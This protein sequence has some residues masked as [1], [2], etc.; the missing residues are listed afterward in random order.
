MSNPIKDF[1]L[2][3][4]ALTP[5]PEAM[6]PPGSD[7]GFQYI[8]GNLIPY[9]TDKL[10]YIQKGYT[11][12]DLV[13]SIVNLILNKAVQAPM[14][15]YR[16][17]DKKA[18]HMYKAFKDAMKSTMDV[19]TASKLHM[20]MRMAKGKAMELYTDD[21]YLNDLLEYPN[22]NECMSEHNRGLWGWKLITGD[23]YE[24]GWEPVSGGL[25]KGKPM[26][27]YGLPSQ[28]ISIMGTKTLPITEEYYLLQLGTEIPYNAADI[29]HEKYWNPEW[30]LHGNQL[31]GLAPLK[32]GLMRLQR[33]NEGQLRSAKTME[34][35]GADVVAYLDN[36]DLVK[37]DFRAALAQM[38]KMKSTWDNE[39]AGNS[40]A[41][42]AIWSTYK[43][44]ATRL[45][46]TPVEMELLE[47]EVVDLR[48]LCNV[49]GGV[50]SQLLNDSAASTMNNISEGEKA[51]TTRCAFPLLTDRER[52]FNRKLRQLPAY[53]NGNVYVEF[54][55]TVY[56]EL[57]EDKE[58]L[59][60]WLN[61]SGLPL[62]KWYAYLNEDVPDFLSEDELNTILLPGGMT[63]LNDLLMTSQN[64]DNDVNSLDAAGA[65]PYPVS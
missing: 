23:Y 52:S 64:L 65:F 47:S 12:N 60:N 40:N 34:N 21:S 14:G 9:K 36:A 8:G 51:L 27:L 46:L 37:S 33:S 32:A 61:K 5:L 59:V 1:F 30:D 44:G 15:A 4:K 3:K 7:A 13:Y 25:A 31:Y 10:T 62:R 29:L 55:R 38:N 20:L 28:Y 22:V 17:V 41:G 56:T 43:V 50:P 16:I 45:G 42:R 48:F 2:G 11:K 18:F 49:F 35:G 63:T 53:R 58:K 39:Q 26:Q 19:N 6:R 24:A 57:E 54:D